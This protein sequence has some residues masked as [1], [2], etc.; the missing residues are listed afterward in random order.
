ML[1]RQEVFVLV[2]S[3]VSLPFSTTVAQGP[4]APSQVYT[5]SG[6]VRDDAKAPVSNAELRLTREGDVPRLTRTGADGRFG[7]E[8][9]QP[10]PVQV[11]VRRLGYKAITKE[12]A[13]NG[14]AASIPVDFALE[15]AA[16]EVQPV[17]VEGEDEKLHEF[18]ERERTN[19]F[20]KYFDGAEIRRRDPRL[21]SDLLRTIPGV[22][23]F[24]ANRIQNRI[25]MRGCSPTIWQNGMKQYGAELDDV[26]QPND[27]AGIEVYLSWAGLPPQYQDR[28]NP[29][30]GAILVWTRDR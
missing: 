12:V 11:S 8:K 21:M 16:T 9:V 15:S 14:Q 29:G 18:Y 13:V 7:F 27:V 30:C 28:E 1:A 5:L 10:G 24:S 6:I 2:G 17:F 23:I 22:N 20:G 4:S 26:A 19:N 25:Q 3:L